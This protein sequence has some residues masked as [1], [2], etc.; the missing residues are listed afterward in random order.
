MMEKAWHARTVCSTLEP[1]ADAHNE[2]GSVAV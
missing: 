2:I 1:A